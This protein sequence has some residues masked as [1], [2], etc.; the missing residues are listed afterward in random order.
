VKVSY[1]LA[2]VA[3][4]ED[5]ARAGR[6]P[7]RDWL[8]PAGWKGV[9]RGDLVVW[10]GRGVHVEMVRGFK[11]SGGQVYVLSD[12]GNTSSGTGGSESN[13]G[14]SYRRV[15]PLSQV[16]GFARVN[17]S[18][19]FGDRLAM[20]LEASRASVPDPQ[21]RPRDVAVSDRILLAR[22]EASRLASEPEAFEFRDALRS[23]L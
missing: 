17:Y 2:S 3:F 1:R 6:A 21:S 14:G 16:H 8:A 7:F 18:G 12:G 23:A 5:D 15:R 20:A 9:L 10:F 11:Q 19:G 22:L 4:I 13:G